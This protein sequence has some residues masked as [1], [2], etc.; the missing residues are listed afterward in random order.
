MND[1]F[2]LFGAIADG[3][4]SNSN[5][6]R[7]EIDGFTV[8]TVDTMDQGPE[9]AI[10]DVNGAH[11]VGHYGTVEEAAIGHEMWVSK[12]KNGLRDVLKLGYGS[13][14]DAEKITL[15]PK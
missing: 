12:I 3:G 13:L 11:P 8:S 15:K 14:V 1:I 7:T 5:I 6:D 9:T 10:I 4:N 2:N